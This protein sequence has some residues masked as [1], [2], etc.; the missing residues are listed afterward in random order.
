[1]FQLKDISVKVIEIIPPY[2]QTQLGGEF[3]TTDPNAMPLKDLHLGSDANSQ[4]KNNSQG[5]EA[6]VKRV[7]PHRFAA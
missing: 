5:E 3:Q 2:I 6:L 7:Y 4:K 1:M